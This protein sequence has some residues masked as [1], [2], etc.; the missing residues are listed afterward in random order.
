MKN[1]STTWIIHVFA[2]LHAAA[3][4]CCTLLGVRDSL[5]LT[6]LTMAMT[7]IICFLENLTVE[8]TISSI[9][10]V[11]ILGFLLGNLAALFVFDQLP[12]V[13][14]HSVS[15]AVVTELLG[16]GLYGFANLFPKE[17]PAEYDRAQS[18]EKHRIL[19]ISSIAVIFGIRFLLA[20]KY[21]GNIFKDSGIVSVLVVVTVFAFTYMVTI[22][23]RMQR[24][25]TSQRT[26]RHQAEFRY[27]TLKHQVNPHF[28]FNSLNV[29]D[30]IVADG[31]REE[32]SAYI[33]K[34]ANIYRYLV[35]QEGERLVPLEDEI[36]FTRNYR[37]LMQIRFPEGLT[38]INHGIPD[39][40]PHGYIVPCT[41]QLLL[42]N[43]I[44]HNA[45]SAS[46]P[47]VIEVTTDGKSISMENTLRPKAFTRPSTGIGLQYIRNQY[48]DLAGAEIQVVK[49]DTH[50]KVTLPILPYHN[51]LVTLPTEK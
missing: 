37:E 18:W 9:V 11:N 25:A 42:E 3:T 24:E 50:F 23:I 51:N 48:R 16:W 10:L 1:L 46:D 36:E 12:P 21:T 5:L 32:A 7:V 38:F 30:S 8:I 44:K 20:D 26:R 6:I 27:M 45:F 49:T 2:L 35:K 40:P 14:Q 13:W 19:L 33:H 43:A 22:A 41:L 31:T 34:M 39:N 28:L 17:G 47:L 29:L 15:T 4:I